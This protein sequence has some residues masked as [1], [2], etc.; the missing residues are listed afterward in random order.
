MST[1]DVKNTVL[2]AKDTATK[3]A[4]MAM[5]SG[6]A[7]WSWHSRGVGGISEKLQN[8]LLIAMATGDM[9]G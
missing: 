6:P 5:P 7:F 3:K 2:A 9:K 1:Y 4:D 8:Q